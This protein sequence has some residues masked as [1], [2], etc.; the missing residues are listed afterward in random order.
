MAQN[1]I[2]DLL[3][4]AI[5]LGQEESSEN[6]FDELKQL[7]CHFTWNLEEYSRR[8]LSDTLARLDSKEK[9]E[10]ISTEFL[11]EKLTLLGFLK[12][13]KED[14]EGAEECFVDAASDVEEL[15]AKGH[16]EDNEDYLYLI[17]A[18]WAWLCYKSKKSNAEIIEHLVKAKNEFKNRRIHNSLSLLS[19][20]AFAFSK[21][22][23]S[24]KAY[25]VSLNC[26]KSLMA[27][28]GGSKQTAWQRLHLRIRIRM[29]VH[30]EY[31][32]G[33]D[34]LKAEIEHHCREMLNA[35]IQ[36]GWLL[37]YIA[38]FYQKINSQV[39]AEELIEK[40]LRKEEQDVAVYERAGKFY[41]KMAKRDTSQERREIYLRK[42]LSNL[43]K[44]YKMK[45]IQP[46]HFYHWYG[47]VY[48][49][50]YHFDKKTYHLE[51]AA[52]FFALSWRE[53]NNYYA[54][55]DFYHAKMELWKRASDPLVGERHRKEAEDICRNMLKKLLD[56]S[57]NFCVIDRCI[58][59]YIGADYVFKVEKRHRTSIEAQKL[60]IKIQP[61]GLNAKRVKGFVEKDAK[62]MLTKKNS[63]KAEALNTMAFIAGF[64]DKDMERAVTLYDEILSIERDAEGQISHVG[65]LN[66]EAL[67]NLCKL[68]THGKNFREARLLVQELKRS[69]NYTVALEN[70]INIAEGKSFMDKFKVSLI[71]D[72]KKN[73]IKRDE[74]SYTRARHL[75]ISVAKHRNVS[76]I[77][78]VLEL[79]ELRALSPT[80]EALSSQFFSDLAHMRLLIE[81]STAV[82]N[83]NE[84]L[85]TRLLWLEKQANDIYIATLEVPSLCILREA[86]Y[87]LEFEDLKDDDRQENMVMAITWG[88]VNSASA[89]IE[90][91]FGMKR[92]IIDMLDA[93]KQEQDSTNLESVKQDKDKG[94]ENKQDIEGSDEETKTAQTSANDT[95]EIQGEKDKES[96]EDTEVEWFREKPY[97]KQLLSNFGKH[98]RDIGKKSTKDVNKEIGWLLVLRKLDN[99][100]KHRKS[101]RKLKLVL[102]KEENDGKPDFSSVWSVLDQED[103]DGKP[104]PEWMKNETITLGKNKIEHGGKEVEQN[105]IKVDV[106]KL[107]RLAFDISEKLKF[108]LLDIDIRQNIE[109]SEI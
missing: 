105:I 82:K 83:Q 8:P 108:E 93:K 7:H 84:D 72:K 2:S 24:A 23:L 1:R 10:D 20:K 4:R 36:P 69:S 21:I 30:S 88:L 85:L 100:N 73:Y 66:T 11:V 78:N 19:A 39:N 33:G 25:N 27:R 40:A 50:S 32:V 62:K 45:P 70:D 48:L 42:A 90:K 3:E 109:A 76:G 34:D 58:C 16:T 46:S 67:E 51:K 68:Q 22:G 101:E 47:K 104:L 55:C 91:V 94:V 96:K 81:R 13:E 61:E 79:L 44:A 35:D 18:N 26:L 89:S 43:K 63:V 92:R 103:K 86:M 102:T 15:K 57:D 5:Q 87:R 41:C 6:V 74:E 95:Q 53:S 49:T 106:M 77:G 59:Y 12:T 97:L 54:A 65:T 71:P 60:L 56:N 31:T 98:Y 28:E 99:D 14:F 37:A 52:D 9:Y 29:Y 64:V 80:Q 107:I 75:F 38:Q 17:Y